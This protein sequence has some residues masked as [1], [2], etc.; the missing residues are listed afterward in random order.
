MSY[1]ASILIVDDEIDLCES[2]QFFF[3]DANY[4]TFL[5]HNVADAYKLIQENKIDFVISDIRMPGETGIDLLK[6]IKALD[7]VKPVVYLISGYTDISEEDCEGLGAEEVIRKP[8]KLE[9]LFEIVDVK[10]HKL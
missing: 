9:D 1:V 2:I 7:P 8:I 6:K 3:E 10:R 5:A 4:Q